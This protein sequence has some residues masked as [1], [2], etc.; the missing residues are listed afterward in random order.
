MIRFYEIIPDND[1]SVSILFLTDPPRILRG[2]FMDCPDT[3]EEDLMERYD[4]YY[5]EAEVIK[6]PF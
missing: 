6:W 1:G 5:N 2:L 3:F 4:D